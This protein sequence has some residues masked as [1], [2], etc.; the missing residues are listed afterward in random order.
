[1]RADKLVNINLLVARLSENMQKILAT[2]VYV[3]IFIFLIFLS[4]NGIKLSIFS[5]RRVFQGIPGFSYSWVMV[6]I[7]VGS[8]LQM[9]TIILKIRDLY[10]REEH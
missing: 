4:Y 2:V 10:K 5:H 9:I 7:P 1:M 3:I 6:S 8:V